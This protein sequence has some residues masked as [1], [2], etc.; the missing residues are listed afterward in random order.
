MTPFTR[1]A[2]IL[3]AASL[4]LVP[5]A[6]AGQK[7]VS[8]GADGVAI[9]GYDTRAYWDDGMA[10]KGSDTHQGDLSGVPMHFARKA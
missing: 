7:R 2:F 9:Q 8:T 3:S 6:L 5:P 4:C 10:R 1:R